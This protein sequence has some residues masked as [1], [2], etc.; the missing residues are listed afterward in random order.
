[1]KEEK[2]GTTGKGGVGWVIFFAGFILALVFGWVVFPGMLYSQKAQPI[3]FS[4][5]AHQ[6]STCEDCHSFRPDGS[7]T[8]IPELGKCKECHE[9]QM[10]QTE[11]E[12]LLVEEYIQKDQEIPWKIYA[13]QP[14][15]VYFSHAPHKA[16]GIECVKCHKDVVKEAK[17]PV[18]K[19]NK[20][21]GYSID[22]M[23]MDVCEN[24]HAQRNVNNNCELCHK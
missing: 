12:R 9:S 19:E 17:L 15:N 3:N 6:D 11:D 1:M 16:G 2:S 18:H 4:H 10:G 23:K 24:C 5:A 8:G 22:T 14:D 13:W 7:Y 20:W 21:T